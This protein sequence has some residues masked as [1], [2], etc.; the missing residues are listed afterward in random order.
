MTMHPGH[1]EHADATL[2]EIATPELYRRNAFRVLGLS[3]TVDGAELG[4]QQKI[5][6]RMEKLGMDSPAKPDG[7]LPLHP[8]PDADTLRQAGQRLH[9]RQARLIDELFWFWPLDVASGPEDPAFALLRSGDLAGAHRAWA[10]ISRD[11][12]NFPVAVHNVAVLHHAWVLDCEVTAGSTDVPPKLAK[13]GLDQQWA[14]ALKCWARVTND[15]AFWSRLTARARAPELDDPRLRSGEFVCRLRHSLPEAILGINVGLAIRAARRGDLAEAG[16]HANYV[17]QSEF[18]PVLIERLWERE[19]SPLV[20]H[21]RRVCDPISGRSKADPAHA[22]QLAFAV[23]N[24]CQPLLDGIASMLEHTNHLKQTAFDLVAE[25]LRNCTIDYGNETGDWAMCRQLLEHAV[26]LAVGDCLQDRLGGDLAQIKKNCDA[27]EHHDRL[28]AQVAAGT[29]Y[30]TTIHAEPPSAPS[31]LLGMDNLVAQMHQGRSA[32]RAT[33]PQACVCCMGRPDRELP[34]SLTWE[35]T[36]GLGHYKR[37]LSFSFPICKSCRQHELEYSLRWWWLI[38]I[39]AVGS[40]VAWLLLAFLMPH[41]EW[42]LFVFL[43]AMLTVVLMFAF[44]RIITLTPLDVEHASRDRP[45]ALINASDDR[46]VFEFTN[47]LYADAF[48]R[49]NRVELAERS[50][51]RTPRGRHLVPGHG[52][53]QIALIAVV[54][55]AIG[56]TIVYAM[57][58]E[59]WNRTPR[60]AMVNAS[61]ESVTGGSRHGSPPGGHARDRQT[62][63]SGSESHQGVPQ[64]RVPLASQR[65]EL[66]RQIDAGR[67]RITTLESDITRMDTELSALAT[68]LTSYRRQVDEFERRV[69]SGQRV[70]NASYQRAIDNHNR[71]VEQHN[72]LLEERHRVYRDYEREFDAVNDMILRYNRRQ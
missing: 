51:V 35:E 21:V 57:M 69:R 31:G 6:E 37:S 1:P 16:R 43:G 50:A 70:D 7:V 14:L 9:D 8:R 19:V 42:T 3:V 45:V 2:L 71:I 12:K 52:T 67:R 34:V 58:T 32:L 53:L 15:D 4:R 33:I 64:Q 13:G 40:T 72:D 61:G 47:P 5:L 68:Q 26:E 66:S 24:E 60:T 30:Q 63:R 29:A 25:T 10:A 48:A 62:S 27:K 11:D 36:R 44:S 22:D 17:H 49:A 55:G 65:S 56:H 59:Y 18:D 23:R 39:T 38:L 41:P 20:D 54:F 46:A 28:V